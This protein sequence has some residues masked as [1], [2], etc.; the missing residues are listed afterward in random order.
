MRAT[1]CVVSTSPLLALPPLTR[2]CQDD[3]RGRAGASRRAL[4]LACH[5]PTG[6]HALVPAETSSRL[7]STWTKRPSPRGGTVSHH[8]AW[9]VARTVRAA[10]YDS[11]PVGASGKTRLG[12]SSRHGRAHSLRQELE[13]GRAALHIREHTLRGRRRRF[14]PGDSPTPVQVEVTHACSPPHASLRPRREPTSRA[15]TMMPAVSTWPCQVPQPA[16]ATTATASVVSRGALGRDLR[17]AARP[18]G[19]P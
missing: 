12:Q 1:S 13:A 17:R 6:F 2:G 19:A 5:S 3:E 11:D 16:S 9:L 4:V 14:G 15:R 8:P 10:P 18:R 7:A